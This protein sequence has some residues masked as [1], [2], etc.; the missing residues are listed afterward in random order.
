MIVKTTHHNVAHIRFVV[1][2]GILQKDQ[3]SPLRHIHAVVRKLKAHR[4]MQLVCK[5]GLLV[6]AT[7]VIGVFQN[8][9]L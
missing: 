8:E 2:I 6:R 5:D 7:V 3:R 1:T 4:Q 9:Q